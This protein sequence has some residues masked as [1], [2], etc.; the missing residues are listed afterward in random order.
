MSRPRSPIPARIPLQLAA[1]LALA[2]GLSSA[3]GE[4]DASE[5]WPEGAALV[6]DTRSLEQLLAQLARLEQTPLARRAEQL[7]EALPSC[8]VVESRAAS[9]ELSDLWRALA[10]LSPSSDLGALATAKRGHDLA[11]S[12]PG[13]GAHWVGSVALLEGGDVELELR[14]PAGAGRGLVGL[15]LPGAEPAGTAELSASNSLVHARVRPHHGL[16]LASL[17]PAE[18][19][20]DRLFRLKSELFTGVALD[21]VWEIAVYLPDAGEPMPPT[22]LALNFARRETAIAGMEDFIRR[23]QQQW[24]VAR[25]DF[26]LGAARGACL[27][28]LAIMPGLAPCY[29]A[30]ER[31][32]VVGWNPASV[33]RALDSR[34]DDSPA[35]GAASAAVV[36][37]DRIAAADRILAGAQPSEAPP[38]AYPWRAITATGA[39]EGADY[40]L[41]LRFDAGRDS[42]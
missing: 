29:V 7:R 23:L 16:D 38:R 22:A 3:C 2:L 20:A 39:R 18:S 8:P 28:D 13:A 4:I 12:A 19:Q 24:P 15:A 32:L 35:L 30:T 40:R 34:A 25:T 14:L 31:A 27:L 26:E 6:A 1:A 41:R 10:C 5:R 37:L 33:R 17:V 11:F 21:G 9:G 36:R 42:T